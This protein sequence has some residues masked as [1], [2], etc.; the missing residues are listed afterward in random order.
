MGKDDVPPSELSL[1][2]M[3]WNVKQMDANI[4]LIA[5]ALQQIVSILKNGASKDVMPF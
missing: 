2:Y 5:E 4:K 3:A 1:K